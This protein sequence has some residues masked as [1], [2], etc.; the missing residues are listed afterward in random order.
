MSKDTYEIELKQRMIEAV[1]AALRAF[2]LAHPDERLSG[3]AICTDDSAAAISHAFY[4]A[5]WFASGGREAARFVAA[6]WPYDDGG[7]AF[8]AVHDCVAVHVAV[9]TAL[10]GGVDDV[11]NRAH[12]RHRR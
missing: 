1:P 12:F 10:D 3:F 7:E 4:S 2:A 9:A 8:D 6:D 5:E 11:V